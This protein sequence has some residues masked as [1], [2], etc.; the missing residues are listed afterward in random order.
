MGAAGMTLRAPSHDDATAVMAVVAARD[1]AD[2]GCVDFTAEDLQ[3][4]WAMSGF[5]LA[6]DAVVCD[7]GAGELAAYAAVRRT[8]GVAFVAP[9]HEGLGIGTLL[10]EWLE[11][12]ERQLGRERHRQGIASTNAPARGLLLAAG[13][14]PERS[15]TRM[16]LQ[17]E[18]ERAPSPRPRPR[19]P[20]GVTLRG[21]EL[22]QDAHALYGVDAESFAEREDYIPS[23][24]A[25]FREEHLEEHDVAPE[26]S[27]VAERDGHVVGF[28]LARRW[29]ET[30]TGF[31]AILA[32]APRAQRQGIGGAMLQA[33]FARFLA[34]GLHEAQLGVAS[35]NPDALKLYERLGMS[36]RFR[37]DTFERPVSADGSVG[38]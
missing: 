30:K 25:A 22:P 33:A 28:L 20:A 12:R 8:H 34:D 21:L 7:D 32:V 9:E 18:L 15:Y 11:R 19:P 1:L 36:P 10:R 4:E 2:F 14:R 29:E 13:Y 26:L 5:D 17:L 27:A 16:M 23:T 37:I 35:S 3:D 6:L 38:T 31:V 24:F